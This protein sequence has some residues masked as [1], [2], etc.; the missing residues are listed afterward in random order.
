MNFRKLS[1]ATV[2]L[3]LLSVVPAF[4]WP[5]CSGQWVSV[6]KGTTGGTLYNTGDLLFQCQ[7]TPPPSTNPTSSNSSS[8][9]SSSSNSNSG[10]TATGGNS[11][12][13]AKAT[14]GKSTST[15]GVSNSGNSSSS[16][17]VKNSGNSTATAAGGAGGNAQ[18]SQTQQQS[19]A[20]TNS[21]NNAAYNS[22]TNIAAP[23][24]P[25]DTAYAPM[26]GVT[27]PCFK[28]FG[29]GIQT[30]PIGGSFGGGKIDQNCA[31]LEAARQ[32]PSKLARCK[33][34]ITNKFVKAAGVTLDDCMNATGEPVPTVVNPPSPISIVLPSNT[35][36]AAILAP[37]QY[38]T[39]ITVTPPTER[40]LVGICTFA[41]A[42][43]CQGP[44][45]GPSVITVSSI[46]RQMLDAARKQLAANPNSILYV[47]GNRNPAEAEVVA[48][49]RA[50]N[51]RRYLTDSGIK[52]SKIDV[53]TGTGTSRTVELWAGPKQ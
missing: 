47:I 25:V 44:Y 39:E 9:S 24:I 43:S 38:N 46:C 29:A 27:I 15:S 41:K 32:A 42:I 11:N 7:T 5:A 37:A 36:V 19:A 40:Q 16:S 14:G 2:L 34:Y 8:S 31:A 50:N 23:K 17:G 45:P 13:G 53:E 3:F 35:P 33:V 12:S 52:G 10:A 21:G 22:E 20:V 1:V 30:V 4:A 26:P 18:Q 6:P 49:S 48:E 28:G 51:V